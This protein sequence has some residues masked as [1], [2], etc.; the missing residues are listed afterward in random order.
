MLQKLAL[1]DHFSLLKKETKL[2]KTKLNKQIDAIR[3]KLY[4]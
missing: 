4:V 2:T 3:T 1:T